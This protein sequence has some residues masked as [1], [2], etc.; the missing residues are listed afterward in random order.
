METWRKVWR[1]GIA[2]QLTTVGLRALQQALVSDDERLLQGATTSPPP[3]MCVQDWAVEGACVVG[4]CGWQGDGL[5]TVGEVEEYFARVCFEVDQ[6][7]GEPAALSPGASFSD[8]KSASRR[9]CNRVPEFRH[10]DH[11]P[12]LLAGSLVRWPGS[13]GPCSILKLSCSATIG[14]V[15]LHSLTDFCIRIPAIA[16]LLATIVGMQASLAGSSRADWGHSG[17]SA[18]GPTRIAE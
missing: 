6:A 12:A 1:D 7:L 13:V 14:A 3:L 16:I 9:L 5:Q 11:W 8:I 4:F 17:R 15:A 2:G 10:A 18:A